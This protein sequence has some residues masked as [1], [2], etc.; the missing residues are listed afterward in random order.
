VFDDEL[1][2]LFCCR[3]LVEFMARSDIPCFDS[4]AVSLIRLP[5]ITPAGYFAYNRQVRG[6]SSS[7]YN[8]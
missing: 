4:T 7:S 2:V 3:M 6:D 5:S 8:T 1:R